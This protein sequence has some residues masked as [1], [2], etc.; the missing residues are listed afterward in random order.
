M[1]YLTYLYNQYRARVLFDRCYGES[2]NVSCTVCVCVIVLLVVVWTLLYITSKVS[3]DKWHHKSYSVSCACLLNHIITGNVLTHIYMGTH[4]QACLGTRSKGLEF[5]SHYQSCVRILGK[6]HPT[7]SLV[8]MGTGRME[9]FL[10]LSTTCFSVKN[11]EPCSVQFLTVGEL[12]WSGGLGW[13]G[14]YET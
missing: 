3:F 13:R 9:R 8:R 7:S 4:D 6:F 11:A 1:V 10:L 14:G 12:G 2:S 5:N